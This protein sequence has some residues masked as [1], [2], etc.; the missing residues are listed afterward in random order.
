[1]SGPKPPEPGITK[2][3]PGGEV[4]VAQ[5]GERG[6]LYE[7]RDGNGIRI[8][9]WSWEAIC[10]ICWGWTARSMGAVAAVRDWHSRRFGRG[11]DTFHLDG[12]DLRISSWAV[13][14]GWNVVLFIEGGRRIVL[15]ETDR[16]VFDSATSP[17][18]VRS[19]AHPSP[20][21]HLGE[22]IGGAEVDPAATR[23]ALTGSVPSPQLSLF[24]GVS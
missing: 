6:T 3:M 17:P 15:D 16:V 10:H 4:V 19:V 1:M 11:R 13:V 9:H 18:S 14:G 12:R 24:G 8:V 5:Q 23:A 2:V 22:V 20:E 21:D 7:V